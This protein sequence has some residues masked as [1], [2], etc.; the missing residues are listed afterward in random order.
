[1]IDFDRPDYTI[2]VEGEPWPSLN[3]FIGSRGKSFAL[4]REKQEWGQLL[5]YARKMSACP[6]ATCRR[7]IRTTLYFSRGVGGHGRDPDNYAKIGNDAMVRAGIVQDD[8]QGHAHF[9]QYLLEVD[10]GRPRVRIEVWD[11]PIEEE[12]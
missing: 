1:M 12:D 5:E 10:K 8:S 9:Y 6:E 2:E 4:T 3:E 7:L 11:I